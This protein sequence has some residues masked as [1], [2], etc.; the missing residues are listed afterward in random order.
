M[1]QAY[2]NDANK[3]KQ[4]KDDDKKGVAKEA[5]AKKA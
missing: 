1:K 4:M 2:L 5:L 3:I